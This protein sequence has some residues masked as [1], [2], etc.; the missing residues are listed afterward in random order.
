MKRRKPTLKELHALTRELLPRWSD[1]RL[2]RIVRAVEAG[3]TDGEYGWEVEVT[4]DYP[5]A[6]T[7]PLF[8][9]VEEVERRGLPPLRIGPPSGRS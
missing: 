6:E 1:D 2:R 3:N 9:L 7:L 8:L 4:E 5:L